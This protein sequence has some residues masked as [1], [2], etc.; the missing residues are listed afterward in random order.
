[1]DITP[2]IIEP[3]TLPPPP[4]FSDLIRATQFGRYEECRQYLES[5][6]FDINQRD[7]ENVALL[8]WAAINNQSSIVDY[9][10]SKGADINAIG[11]DLKSTPLQWATRQGHLAMVVL[12]I[13]RGADYSILDGEGCNVLH[14]AAQFGH[15]AIVAY[16]VAKGIDIDIPD[17]NGMTALMWSAYRVS[18]A[19]PTRLLITLGSSLK[20]ADY[21]HKNTALHWAVYAKNLTAITLLLEANA[22]VEVLNVDQE[23]PLDMARKHQSPWL[24]K[25]LETKVKETSPNDSLL[26][27]FSKNKHLCDIAR[28]AS[29]FFMYLLIAYILD[30]GATSVVKIISLIVILVLL[31]IFCKLIHERCHTTN[32]PVA[33]YLAL[34]FWLY[35]TLFYFLTPY[36]YDNTMVVVLIPISATVQFY[37]YYRCWLTDPGVAIIDR[38]QQLET[39]IKMAETDGYFDAKHFCSTCLIRKPLRSKH[40]SHCNK[41]VAR[42]DH[43]C[44]WVGNCI[45]AKNHKQFLLFLF[46]VTVNLS[47]FIHLTYSYWKSKVV[48]TPAKNLDDESWILEMM[49]T[50]GKG[51]GLS[52]MLSMGVVLGLI[53]TVWTAS[54]LCNQLYLVVWLGMTTNESMNSKRYE[55][56]RHDEHGK[57]LS[58]FD[59]GCCHNFVDF[60]E[61]RFMRKFMQ[62]DIKDW[63]HVYYDSHGEED[64]TI[65]TNNKGDR[66]FKV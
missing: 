20:M 7:A 19:D 31:I 62:T 64:F 61:F 25:M 21:K 34:T 59:R 49:E 16:L 27:A 47:I 3:P 51:L 30:S 56:F 1:M 40:C 43:H 22:D 24:I 52:G 38:T 18:K 37:T 42:F 10:L 53:L 41:C 26:T 60:C 12:L 15:T 55:H 4:Q 8:H 54:L 14:L 29:P 57:P 63:R 2:A 45:G 11:G 35:Y 5:N 66:I 46:S 17:A 58:P 36:I 9:Y 39:I 28:N 65:T 33:V 6:L 32:F 23:S 48:L 44:P 50:I 13:R